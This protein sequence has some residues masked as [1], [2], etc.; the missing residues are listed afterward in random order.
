MSFRMRGRNDIGEG[1]IPSSCVN[2]GYR[3]F[4]TISFSSF[5]TYRRGLVWLQLLLHLLIGFIGL[6]GIFYS[7]LPTWR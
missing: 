6:K 4:A 1:R 2:D 5:R 7:H 3:P